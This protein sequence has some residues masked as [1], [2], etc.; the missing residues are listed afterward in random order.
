VT[1]ADIERWEAEH[2]ALPAGA[3]VLFRTGFEQY[4]PDREAYL[5]TALRGQEGVAALHFP[6]I[7]E[8][9]ARLLAEERDVAA[10]GLD[11]A[12]LD[13]GQST[14]FIAHQILLG[15][16]IPGLENVAGLGAL[17]PTGA[18]VIALPTKIGGG[19]G[20]PLRIVALLPAP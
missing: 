7:S 14:D 19:S 9:A 18:T 6:G 12:S 3:I 1:R 8:E 15:A 16:N 4:W 17:P 2:G 11:T 5:G 10:V 13:Y 20:G